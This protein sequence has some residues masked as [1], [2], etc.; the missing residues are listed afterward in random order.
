[1]SRFAADKPE[2]PMVL[3]ILVLIARIAV[4]VILLQAAFSK[5]FGQPEAVQMF[6]TL[7]GDPM[8]YTLAVFETLGAIGI[9][10]PI[11]SGVAAIGVTVLFVIVVVVNSVVFG[12]GVVGLAVT[13]LVLSAA[14]AVLQRHQNVRLIRALKSKSGK[15]S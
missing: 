8:R 9:L 1:V 6:D 5:F 10:I 14:I 7:G 4:A 13:V 12:P 3:R 15:E 11:L 2:R